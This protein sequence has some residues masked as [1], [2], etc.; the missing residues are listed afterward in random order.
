MKTFT[1]E[2]WGRVDVFEIV[3][4]IPKGYS[5]WNIPL[6]DMCGFLPLCQCY[7]GTHN[8]K[9]NTLKAIYI[10]DKDAREFIVH[11]VSLGINRRTEN[12]QKARDMIKALTE[13]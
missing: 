12:A 3:E 8:I 13:K 5:V 1:R 10:E 7:A 9:M 2:A 6:D 4:A 11:E